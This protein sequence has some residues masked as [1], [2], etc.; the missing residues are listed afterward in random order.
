[1][2]NKTPSVNADE[3]AQ[4]RF[5]IAVSILLLL[6]I[7]A[8]VLQYTGHGVFPE[9]KTSTLW[10][11]LVGFLAAWLFFEYQWSPKRRD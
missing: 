10:G 1:M 5:R 6:D 9:R 4:R 3:R 11:F 8:L 2:L 7:I